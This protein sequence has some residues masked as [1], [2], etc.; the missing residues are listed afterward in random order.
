LSIDESENI[1]NKH[2]QVWD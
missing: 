1:S 2:E